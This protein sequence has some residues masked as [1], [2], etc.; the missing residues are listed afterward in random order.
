MRT[1]DRIVA[2]VGVD[3]LFI[4]DTPD[5]VSVAHC[6]HLQ[7]VKEVVRELKARGYITVLPQG[8]GFQIKRSR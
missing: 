6:D 4:V 3:G 8:P 1:E 5:A 7:R 2:T